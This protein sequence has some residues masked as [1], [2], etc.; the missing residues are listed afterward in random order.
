MAPPDDNILNQSK[1]CHL[2]AKFAFKFAN[3][4]NGAIWWPNLQLMQVASSG[5][6]ICNECKW[7]HVV[8][9]FSP[10]HG[11]NFWVRCAS[12][13][14]FTFALWIFTFYYHK[15]LWKWCSFLT[16]SLTLN[17]R[18]IQVNSPHPNQSH[19]SLCQPKEAF[20]IKQRESLLVQKLW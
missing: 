12:G 18:T 1:L 7:C 13:N 14:V 10:S 19:E 2:V 5:G 9:K 8:A 3:N 4:A 16:H 20:G 11:V 6:Q 17:G 15:T